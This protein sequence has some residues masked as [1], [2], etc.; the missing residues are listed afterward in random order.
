MF[1]FVLGIMNITYCEKDVYFCFRYYEHILTVRKMFIFVLGI[2]NITYCEKDV[3]FCFRYY[4]HN[5]QKLTFSN[6]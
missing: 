1:I 3:Y 6:T 5:L 4:E 2:M